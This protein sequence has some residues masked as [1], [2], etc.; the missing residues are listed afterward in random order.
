MYIKNR[1]NSS[2]MSRLFWRRR[3][4]YSILGK[5]KFKKLEDWPIQSQ[6]SNISW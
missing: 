4:I 5:W 2:W 3:I 6:C 1:W